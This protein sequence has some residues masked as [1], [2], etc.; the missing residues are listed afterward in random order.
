VSEAATRPPAG[1]QR[2]PG[3]PAHGRPGGE[4]IV[5]GTRFGVDWVLELRAFGEVEAE[6]TQAPYL[7]GLPQLSDELLAL[8]Q[9]TTLTSADESRLLNEI[10]RIALLIREARQRWEAE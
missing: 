7:N 3:G 1:E 9:L 4:I 6:P 2:S 5:K 8:A 10:D